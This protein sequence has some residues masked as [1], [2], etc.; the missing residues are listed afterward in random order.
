MFE[1]FGFESLTAPQVVVW[2]GLLLG[3]VFGFAAQRSRFC[4]RR[5]VV[6]S[7]PSD[8][9]SARAVWLIAL[10]TAVWG[11]QAAV[12]WGLIEFSE[13]RFHST[14][15]PILA[16][17][18]GGLSFGA[19]MVLARGCA[20]RL[21]VLGASGN[22]R[23][24]TVIAV[25]AI[26]AHMTMKGLLAPIR[27]VIASVGLD[28]APTLPFGAPFW[29]LVVAAL[30]LVTALQARVGWRKLAW[31]LVIGT[32]VPLGW[33][34]T[35]YVFFD[36]F[37]P[38]ALESLSFT[39]PWADSLFYAVASTSIAA[40]FGAGLVGGTLLGAFAAASLNREFAWQSFSNPAETGRYLLG[41]AMMGFGGVLAGGCTIGA[42]LGGVPTLSVAALMTLLS[43]IAGA[44][45]A[46]AVFSGY[47]AQTT[48]RP[49]QPAE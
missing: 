13:H 21:T 18:L 3:G 7:D 16:L 12:Y 10:A 29:L 31:P 27:N 26:T 44:R 23:A 36:D 15:L 17:S 19:G 25:F 35:G 2:F 34:G 39:A 30:A 42:G 33:V 32:L 46:H 41:G 9:N 20:S 5:A 40:N 1:T 49:L 37:D 24:L 4:L 47:G 38:V 28:T 6:G 14:Q 11:T 48:T 45:L 22:L 43:I 8:R